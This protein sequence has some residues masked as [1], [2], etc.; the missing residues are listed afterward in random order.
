MPWYLGSGARIRAATRTDIQA[1]IPSLVRLLALLPRLRAVVFLGGK[2]VRAEDAVSGLRPGLR[3]FR[4]P[5]PSPL[6]VNNAPGNRDRILAALS[7]VAH[8]I[9]VGGPVA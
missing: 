6:Y 3:L 5:H 1:G 9:D 8:F 7:E 2:A 4:S